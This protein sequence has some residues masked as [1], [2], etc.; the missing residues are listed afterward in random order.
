MFEKEGGDIDGYCYSCDTYVRHPYGKPATIEDIPKAERIGKTK[1]EMQEEMELIAKCPVMDLPDR[2]LRKVALDYYGIKIGLSEQDGKTPKLHYYPYTLDGE[3]KAYKARLIENKRMWSVGDQK[4]VDLFG[5]EQA[6]SSGA[7]R[8]IVVEGELDAVALKAIIDRHNDDKYEDF[9][10]AITSLPHGAAS[11]SRDLSRLAKKIRK[12]FKE[13]T[14]CFDG[15]DAGLR[16]TEEACKIF[17]EATV[18]SLPKK[19]AND[20]I[21]KGVTKAAFKA[22]MFNHQKNKNSRLVTLDEVWEASKKP[23]EWGVSWPWE[24]VTD[25]TRGIRLG[26]TIYIGAAQ[27]MG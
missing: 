15:D 23:P 11:A 21:L 7:R 12:H 17:P 19:D 14:F 6:I 18:V 8:L 10:P 24:T 5:W 9:K 25:L 2:K 27:K 1:E 13:I 22:V 16:A 4:E 20:C 3:L 26:E